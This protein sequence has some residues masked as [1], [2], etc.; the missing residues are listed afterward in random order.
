MADIP[1]DRFVGPAV[2]IDISGRAATDKDTGVTVEDLQAW[3]E[4]HG[5]I[6]KGA[7]VLMNSG[8]GQYI[9]NV[10]LFRG[11]DTDDTRYLHFPGKCIY[12]NQ[13]APFIKTLV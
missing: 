11:N 10:T 2:V 12:Q 3:E 9:N 1:V 4:K 13:K 6:P 7:I 8:W 5:K